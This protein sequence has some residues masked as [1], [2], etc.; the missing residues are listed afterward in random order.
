T[1]I[2]FL[3]NSELSAE[4]NESAKTICSHYGV[5]CIELHDIDKISGHPSVKG[6]RA[7]ADQVKAAVKK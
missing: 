5:T 3:L 7:I 2:Y 1:D 4:I 6:M